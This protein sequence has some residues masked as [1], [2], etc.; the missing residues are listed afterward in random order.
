MQRGMT[1]ALLATMFFL[2]VIGSGITDG[3]EAFEETIRVTNACCT[4]EQHPVVSG[5]VIVWQWHKSG[6][7][8]DGIRYLDISRG[9]METICMF[10]ISPG[11]ETLVTDDDG[12]QEAPVI[13]R[14]KIV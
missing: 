2:S 12:D 9:E 4:K 1:S 5:D 11:Q 8:D 10:D 14:D 3:S 6:L 13:F 7:P